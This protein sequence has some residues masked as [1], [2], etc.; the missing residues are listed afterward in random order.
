MSYSCFHSPREL[1]KL[2]TLLNIDRI[3][4]STQSVGID[5][6]LEHYGHKLILDVM[7]SPSS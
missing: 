4:F 6:D 1:G 3:N 2:I 7:V 5:G